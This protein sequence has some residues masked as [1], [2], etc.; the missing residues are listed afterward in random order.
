VTAIGWSAPAPP[1]AAYPGS[2]D[3][4]RDPREWRAW[5][6][7]REHRERERAEVSAQLRA[8]D[9]QRDRFYAENRFRPGELR[10]YDRRYDRRRAELERRLDELRPVAWR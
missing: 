1:P 2:S 7:R 8:L 10:R 4:A 6:E 3:R 5:R 9:A